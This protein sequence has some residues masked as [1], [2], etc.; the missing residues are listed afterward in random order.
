MRRYI[1]LI[2]V[3]L[4]FFMC[5]CSPAKAAE[6]TWYSIFDYGVR[7]DVANANSRFIGLS[8]VSSYKAT[9]DF[10]SPMMISSLDMVL[11]VKFGSLSNVVFQESRFHLTQIGSSSSGVYYRATLNLMQPTGFES[12][13]LWFDG[14]PGLLVYIESFDASTVN[15][16]RM[17]ISGTASFYDGRSS[18]NFTY[19]GN[20]SRSVS[21]TEYKDTAVHTQIMI[22][23]TLY[24]YNDFIFFL[25]NVNIT[26]VSC[27]I[28]DT[29]IPCEVVYLN[30]NDSDASYTTFSVKIDFTQYDRKSSGLCTLYLSGYV[31]SSGVTE[32]VNVQVS[33]TSASGYVLGNESDPGAYW[34]KMIW[35]DMRGWFGTLTNNMVQ[36]INDFRTD[37]VNH[38]N[39]LSGTLRG[40]FSGLET[41]LNSNFDD[42]IDVLSPDTAPA[43]QLQSEM[44]QQ[45]SDLNSI[46]SAL[47]NLDTPD[48]N[49][50]SGDLSNYVQMDDVFLA[51]NPMRN[52]LN[53]TFFQNLFMI[54]LT[55]MLASYVLY[56][57]R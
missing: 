17:S 33:V 16:D 56:G 3:C 1:S 36:Y 57:K 18:T 50:F 28:N 39:N 23:P 2:C 7:S 55:L 15:L 8:G 54:A 53:N 51:A 21:V 32:N 46:S 45:T 43:D 6:S 22:D 52:A 12:I 35:W 47:E 40:F 26:S 25:R 19:P 30:S 44:D 31:P 4:V 5:I 10:P 20:I 41:N 13:S 38:F 49:D 11:F 37:I 24:D 34:M 29:I 14:V 9:W 42:L 27:Y 48:L